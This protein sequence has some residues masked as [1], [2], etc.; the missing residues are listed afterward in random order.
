MQTTEMNFWYILSSY[1]GWCEIPWVESGTLVIWVA[2]HLH[3]SKHSDIVLSI[4]FTK[5]KEEY[6][7]IPSFS[8]MLSI[9]GLQSTFQ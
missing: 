7:T 8:T 2:K 1:L 9:V 4:T 6:L 5:K 3:K